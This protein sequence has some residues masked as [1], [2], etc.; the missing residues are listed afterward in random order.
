MLAEVRNVM[1]YSAKVTSKGQVTVPVQVRDALG[2]GTG[3]YLVFEV[4]GKYATVA[5]RESALGIIDELAGRYPLIDQE[6]ADKQHAVAAHF[7][8][9]VAAEQASGERYSDAVY[10]A[11]RKGVRRVDE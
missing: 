5:K 2:V 3:D 8:D 1:R 11:G 4:A 7:R 10:V 9:R 6:V